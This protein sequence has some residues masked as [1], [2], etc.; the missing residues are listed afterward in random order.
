MKTISFI[1]RE[2]IERI[3]RHCGL[4]AGPRRT[5]ANSRPP[6]VGTG[7]GRA[8]RVATG[9]RSGVSVGT[10][11]CSFASAFFVATHAVGSLFAPLKPIGSMQ[12][13]ENHGNQPDRGENPKS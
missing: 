12:P 4:W 7:L 5:L 11:A 8:T 1:Q 9:P 3:L 2:V 6:P 10:Q 13:P